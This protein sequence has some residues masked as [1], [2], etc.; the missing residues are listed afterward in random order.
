MGD[1]SDRRAGGPGVRAPQRRY[2]DP[3]G[4]D[5]RDGCCGH[6]QPGAAAPDGEPVRWCVDDVV[7]RTGVL[8]P[9][10]ACVERLR[11]AE[12]CPGIVKR[13]LAG[14]AS[15]SRPDGY[16]LISWAEPVP[17]NAHHVARLTRAGSLPTTAYF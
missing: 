1:R 3:C 15:G 2:R 13:C 16:E 7:N 17:R 5:N 11:R 12:L 6:E 8:T 4:C 10:E 9:E 14:S